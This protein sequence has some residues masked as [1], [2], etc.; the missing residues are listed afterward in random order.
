MEQHTYPTDLVQAQIACFRAYRALATNPHSS[1]T[2]RRRRL[3]HLSA[4][5]L[6]PPYWAHT[7]S[8]ARL[9]GL[10]RYARALEQIRAA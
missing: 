4:Q 5:V 2:A 8:R 1:P 3:L 6:F 9:E 10:R 7:G